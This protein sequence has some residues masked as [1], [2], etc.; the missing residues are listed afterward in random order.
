MKPSSSC[1]DLLGRTFSV[2]VDRQRRPETLGLW[3]VFA[4]IT[5]CTPSFSI[6][7]HFEAFQ[8]IPIQVV[9][10]HDQ[11]IAYLDVGTGPP[12][13]LIHGFGGSMWQWE[14]QQQDL[15][16]H[17]RVITLDLPG[18]GLSDKPDIEYRPDQL[19]DF[20]TR[21]MDAIH[22]SH[23]TLVGNSMGAG[24]AMAMAL[25]HPERVDKLV[26]IGGLPGNIRSALT[27][28]I[29][30]RTLET[31]AP[32]WVISLGNRLFGGWVVKAVLNELVHDRSLL[33][34]AVLERSNLNRRRP[35][36]IQ[37]MLAMKQTLGLWE[38]DYAPRLGTIRHPT[39]VIWGEHD[40]V[41]PLAV[42][43][44]LHHLIKGSGFSSIPAAGHL[45]QWERP[46]LVNRLLIA[47]IQS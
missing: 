45:P 35:G 41:F 30:K 37:P 26:L 33:T 23:A 16:R 8:R 15:A 28:P 7:A 47:Y 42:G 12:V 39:L 11:R 34:P 17:F 18:F 36:L 25:D 3:L 21:F 5:A 27:S 46:D 40:R 4:V 14:H 43:E 44:E 32:S 20:F 24:L 31:R 6:P 22:L 9:T 19:V 38:S 29:V 1:T 2:R 10:V 13:I